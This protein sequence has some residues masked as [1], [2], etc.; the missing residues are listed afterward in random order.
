MSFLSYALTITMK[1]PALSPASEA[2]PNSSTDPTYWR[3]GT[4][5]VGWNC[6][7]FVAVCGVCVCVC[8]CVMGAGVG[9]E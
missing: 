2:A 9:S 5:G 3:E 7:D 6:M 8:V 4:S 1:S